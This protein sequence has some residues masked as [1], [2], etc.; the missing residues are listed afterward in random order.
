[1][2]HVSSGSG[3]ATLRTAIHL[4]LTYLP[5]LLTLQQVGDAGRLCAG[6]ESVPKIVTNDTINL[7]LKTAISI[8]LISNRNSFRVSFGKIASVYF[9]LKMYLYFSN[10][11]GQPREPALCQLYR[12]TFVP[13]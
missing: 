6:N 1:M 12:H 2:W 5:T 3:V 13:Y 7:F 10:G 11:N 4:L 8:L 9:I